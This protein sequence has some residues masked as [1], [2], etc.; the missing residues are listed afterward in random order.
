MTTAKEFSKVASLIGYNK[1]AKLAAKN[2]LH[3]FIE[4][5]DCLKKRPFMEA[6][7]IINV[8]NYEGVCASFITARA[9]KNGLVDLSYCREDLDLQENQYSIYEAVHYGGWFYPHVYEKLK[10]DLI[11][12]EVKNN[13]FNFKKNG[14]FLE[15]YA[16]DLLAYA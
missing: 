14:K 1:A 10:I 2:E 5:L 9:K 4:A 6:T 16:P 11:R 7:N 8:K 3:K 12:W 13:K 15:M